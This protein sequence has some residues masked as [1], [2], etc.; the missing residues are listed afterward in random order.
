MTENGKRKH[1]CGPECQRICDRCAESWIVHG[2]YR[3]GVQ[4]FIEQDGGGG[5]VCNGCA[6]SVL[7]MLH[8]GELSKHREEG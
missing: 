1:V 4:S 5:L 2:M 7:E 6:M 3:W 8:G